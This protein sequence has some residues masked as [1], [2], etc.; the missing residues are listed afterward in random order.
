MTQILFLHHFK[1]VFQQC[2][3]LIQNNDLWIRFKNMQNCNLPKPSKFPQYP[4]NTI[5]SPI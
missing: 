3:Q 1:V 2:K 4:T 5:P